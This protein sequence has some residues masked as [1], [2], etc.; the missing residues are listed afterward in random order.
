MYWL[1]FVRIGSGGALL[2]LGGLNLAWD[3]P[4]DDV[5]HLWAWAFVVGAYIFGHGILDLLTPSA[6]SGPPEYQA[7]MGWGRVPAALKL[8]L[9]CQR[10]E[11]PNRPEVPYSLSTYFALQSVGM[12]SYFPLLAGKALMAEPTES[13]GEAPEETPKPEQEETLKQAGLYPVSKFVIETNRVVT[14]WLLASGAIVLGLV[15]TGSLEGLDKVGIVSLGASVVL[16]LTYIG[17]LT[18]AVAK[19]KDT[20]IIMNL[21]AYRLAALLLNLTLWAFISGIVALSVR[22]VTS[23]S[24]TP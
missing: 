14:Q 20:E 17:T 10:P 13:E 19:E 22:V 18:G 16:G 7:H 23:G 1:D 9:T 11:P 24:A 2:V 21:S 6:S 12:P 15:A 4:D 5:P 3:F 8:L